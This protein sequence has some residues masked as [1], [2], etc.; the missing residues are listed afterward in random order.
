[1]SRFFEVSVPDITLPKF[2]VPWP[3]GAAIANSL[4]SRLPHQKPSSKVP[5]LLGAAIVI[6]VLL[7]L[8]IGVK[9][10]CGRPS[11]EAPPVETEPDEAPVVTESKEG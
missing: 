2:E 3:D 8:A 11:R 6:V 10:M 7:I 5:M 1:M 4:K 9:K